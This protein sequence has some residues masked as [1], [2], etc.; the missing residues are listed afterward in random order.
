MCSQR[1]WFW[2]LM[3]K[4]TSLPAPSVTALMARTVLADD[5][6]CQWLPG[7]N[8]LYSH[9]EPSLSTPKTTASPLAL[10]AALTDWKDPTER[11]VQPLPGAGLCSQRLWPWTEMVK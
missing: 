3:A 4:T 10:T 7:N 1:L 5:R 11:K 2:L 9:S 8:G 6:F